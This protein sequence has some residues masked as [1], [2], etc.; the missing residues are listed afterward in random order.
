M[1][2]SL[3]LC[4]IT[5]IRWFSLSPG[6]NRIPCHFYKNQGQDNKHGIPDDFCSPPDDKTETDIG[7]RDTE[8]GGVQPQGNQD[9]SLVGKKKRADRFEAKL[10][11]FCASRSGW[12]I[13][14]GD[15]I[16]EK[17]LELVPK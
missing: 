3:F 11:N 16:V 9:P 14:F 1:G 2:L 4:V 5:H 10:T 12:D 15:P 8:G 6:V 7:V 13:D 17:N